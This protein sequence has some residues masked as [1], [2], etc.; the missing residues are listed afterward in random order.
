MCPH[1][2]S[3]WF[4]TAGRRWRLLSGRDAA[5]NR[6]ADL[7]GNRGAAES[8]ARRG[9]AERLSPG[10][11]ELLAALHDERRL[12]LVRSRLADERRSRLLREGEVLFGRAAASGRLD[13]AM[14]LA[15]A[16]LGARGAVAWTRRVDTQLGLA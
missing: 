6:P 1:A 2:L 9:T 4:L 15:G 16:F 3:R 14:A 7:P 13:G 12:E 8:C 10:A 5:G 11:V